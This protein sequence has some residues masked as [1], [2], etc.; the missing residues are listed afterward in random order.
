MLYF[1]LL[2]V[3]FY[4]SHSWLA[5]QKV[6]DF[7]LKR[8]AFCFRFYRIFYTLFAVML[9]SVITWLFVCKHDYSYIFLPQAEVKNAGIFL[10]AT[11]LLVIIWSILRYGFVDFTGLNAIVNT[12]HQSVAKPVLNTSGVNSIVRHP[13]YTGV[14][15][16]FL[17]LILIIPTPMTAAGILISFIYLEIGIRLEEEKLENEFGESYRQYKLKVKKVIPFLY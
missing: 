12:N 10:A 14:I 3:F 6:K 4:A 16:A 9:W 2:L 7:V 13:I 5:S 11:G 8:S 15:M 17:G 1:T